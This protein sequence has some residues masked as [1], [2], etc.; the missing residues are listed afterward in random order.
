MYIQSRE[1]V[2]ESNNMVHSTYEVSYTNS[3]SELSDS[4]LRGVTSMSEKELLMGLK[5]RYNTLI[6]KIHQWIERN[7]GISFSLAIGG[8]HMVTTEVG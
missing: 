3:G 2:S 4:I 6:A 5:W 7:H 1:G 8:L